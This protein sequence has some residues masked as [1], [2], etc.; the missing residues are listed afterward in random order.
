MSDIEIEAVISRLCDVVRDLR[1]ELAVLRRS[2][3]RG[4]V[5]LL[6]AKELARTLG[7]S[8]RTLRRL[9]QQRRFPRPVKG[10]RLRWRCGDVARWM[11]AG[12]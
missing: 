12:K 10:V 7:V 3:P 5:E 8:L 9:R 2:S 1:S 6:S 4:N 11:G